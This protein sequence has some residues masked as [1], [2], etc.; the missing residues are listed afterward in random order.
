VWGLAVPLTAL[1]LAPFT[2][3]WAL[4]LLVA[5]PMQLIWIFAN[6]RQ[7]GWASGDAAVYA[8][9]AMLGKFPALEGM[10]AYHWRRMRG[11]TMTIMEHRQS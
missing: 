5:Y 8:F 10:L 2:H 7:R 9:F 6:S 4:L 3:G 1:V 11:K